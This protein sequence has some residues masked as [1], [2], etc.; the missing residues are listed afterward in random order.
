MQKT[1]R[2]RNEQVNPGR[3]SH[4]EWQRQAETALPGRFQKRRTHPGRNGTQ[5]GGSGRQV[6]QAP[7]EVVG[8]RHP[9]RP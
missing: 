9:E 6:T 5:A 8:P 7:A 1:S 4:P 3:T 2:P